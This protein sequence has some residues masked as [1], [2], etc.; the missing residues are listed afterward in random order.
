MLSIVQIEDATS[1]E[2]FR[3]LLDSDDFTFPFDAGVCMPS[4][5]VTLKNKREVAKSIA[6]HFAVFAIKA[7]LDQLKKGLQC[8]RL[9]EVMH[10]YPTLLKPLFLNS[11]EP[12]IT[13]DYIL[14]LFHVQWSPQGS[15]QRE[16]EE[17]V[18]LG[19]HEYIHD[20]EGIIMIIMQTSYAFILTTMIHRWES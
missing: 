19:W 8:L 15:N 3:A 13:A 2:E 5:S 7:E 4:S 12:S 16:L 17:A 6:M 20:T 10:T 18:I 9:L 14:Q 11:G 1:T